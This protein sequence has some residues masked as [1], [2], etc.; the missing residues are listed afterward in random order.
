[1]A[2]LYHVTTRCINKDW[3][4]QPLTEIWET[5]SNYLF[6]IHHAYD[7]KI[8]AFV[9]MSNHYH[10]LIS[11]LADELSD[12]IMYFNRETS[13]STTKPAGRINQTYGSRFYRTLIETERNYLCV[14]KYL[15]QNPIRAGMCLKAEEYPFSTLNGL[16]GGR[17]SII[18][19]ASDDILFPNVEETLAWLNSAPDLKLIDGIR[20]GLRHSAFRLPNDRKTRKP[21]DPNKM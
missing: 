19:L 4:S 18:P 3:F 16:V 7:V 17:H 10:L 2:N 20:R 14:Y 21:L 13:R 5:M 6:F 12:A 1:M 9:L 8:H 11:A 15:Y